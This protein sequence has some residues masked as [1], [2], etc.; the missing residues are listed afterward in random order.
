M[1]QLIDSFFFISLGITF[2]LL[3]LMAFHFKNRVSVLEKK[4]DALTEMCNTIVHEIHVVKQM[5]SLQ[6]QSPV[7]SSSTNFSN[8]PVNTMLY[9]NQISQNESDD[10]SDSD[11]DSNS[12]DGRETVNS[13]ESERDDV[14]L[15]LEIESIEYSDVITDN[16]DDGSNLKNIESEE[17][18]EVHKIQMSDDNVH[19]LEDSMEDIEVTKM[20]EVLHIEEDVASEIPSISTNQKQSSYKKMNVQ[21][22]RMMV[23]SKGLCS[24]PSKMKKQELLKMLDDHENE[25]ENEA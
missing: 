9:T 18:I 4:N 10:D 13:E 11:S 23:I 24:D 17:T 2:V 1:F 25:N 6:V 3:F 12:D 22:L 21:M 8:I 15:S 14:P 19:I 7:H 5:V 16:D 20:D